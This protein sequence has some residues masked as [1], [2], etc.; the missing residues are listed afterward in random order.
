MADGQAPTDAVN[1]RQLQ[2]GAQTAISYTDTYAVGYSATGITSNS[3]S[4][5]R[6]PVVIHNVG[7]GAVAATSTNAKKDKAVRV[8]KVM[9][10]A[11]VGRTIVGQDNCYSMAISGFIRAIYRSFGT[12][13]QVIRSAS[14]VQVSGR[15]SRKAHHNRHF[16]RRQCVGQVE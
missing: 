10:A 15:S 3:P 2:G 5:P 11:P 13:A 12:R 4:T 16:A 8:I 7:G 1:V 14:S 9:L 6:G